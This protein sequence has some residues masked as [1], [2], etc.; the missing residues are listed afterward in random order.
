[1]IP[2]SRGEHLR[3]LDSFLHQP[4]GFHIYIFWC[5]IVIIISCHRGQHKGPLLT[6]SSDEEDSPS[7]QKTISSGA[8][9]TNKK[10]SST[11]AAVTKSTAQSDKNTKSKIAKSR[12]I[13]VKVT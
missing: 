11:D 5:D 10:K 3:R 12:V 8:F 4:H 9:Y 13:M 1:M 2:D 6:H 7:K